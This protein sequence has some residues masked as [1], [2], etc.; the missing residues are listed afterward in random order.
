M[1][2]RNLTVPL[3]GHR[4]PLITDP[5]VDP[6]FGSGAVMICTFGD[7]QDVHW[8]KQ[9]KLELRKAIDRQGRMTAI[10]G[11]YAGMKSADCR[12]AILEDMKEQQI[13]TRQEPLEQRVGACWRCK[14]PIEIMSERQWFV[15]I[16]PEAIM[17]AAREIEWIPDHMFLRIENWVQQME[18]DW[19]ISR[20]RVF[21]TPIPVWFCKACGEMVVPAEEELPVDPTVHRPSRPCPR[22]GSGDFSGEED[23]LDT[24]MDS[25]ISVLNV[26]GWDGKGVP[27]L[28]PAELR[29]RATTS[30]GHGHFTRYSGLSHSLGSVP[31]IRYSSTG[32]SLGKTGTR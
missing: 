1:A 6:S 22:C 10:A 11:K 15:K 8:W 4:V 3:F 7:K 9:H 23:V 19:C 26:T 25:S 31:G 21:A 5:A 27:P 13:L 30:Y 12:K 14:T 17:K 16:D 2:G 28:F 32:W 20:Q 18:W 24:W 29:P